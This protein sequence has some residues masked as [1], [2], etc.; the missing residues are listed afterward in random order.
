MRAPPRPCGDGTACHAC[1]GGTCSAQ[2]ALFRR[3]AFMMLTSIYGG[4]GERVRYRG[5]VSAFTTILREEG[6]MRGLY[7]GSSVTVGRAVLL[8][9]SQV[10]PSLRSV[11]QLFLG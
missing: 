6:L 9:G 4:S 7:R 8:N 3:H 5:L 11:C 10:R 2:V 1:R